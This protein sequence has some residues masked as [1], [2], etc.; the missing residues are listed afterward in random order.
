MQT[1]TMITKRQR[2]KR[3][4][5]SSGRKTLWKND[6]IVAFLRLE[7]PRIRALSRIIF[8]HLVRKQKNYIIHSH[9]VNY[10]RCVK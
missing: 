3:Q 6:S 7:P 4:N 2:K 9:H 1:K 5:N 8:C 10:S